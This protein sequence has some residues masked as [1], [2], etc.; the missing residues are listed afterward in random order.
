LEYKK[1]S[2]GIIK[3]WSI[4]VLEYWSVAYKIRWISKTTFFLF[5]FALLQYSITPWLQ[6]S[7]TP[8]IHR[9]LTY[10]RGT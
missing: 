10:G 7:I 4:G 1:W 8:I 9:G 6:Y 5:D 2:D 3:Q